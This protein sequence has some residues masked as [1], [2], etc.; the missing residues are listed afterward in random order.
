MKNTNRSTSTTDL[1]GL[2]RLIRWCGWGTKLCLAGAGFQGF[3]WAS[4]G[5]IEHGWFTLACVGGAWLSNFS[6]NE[7]LDRWRELCPCPGCQA[8]R[9]RRRK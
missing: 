2:R 3:L 7:C 8:Y 1:R 5:Q 9:A 6:R 4:T